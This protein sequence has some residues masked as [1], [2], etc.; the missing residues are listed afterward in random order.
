MKKKRRRLRYIR[1][2]TKAASGQFVKEERGTVMVL[3]I[4]FA[5]PL[6]MFLFGGFNVGSALITRMR[7]QNVADAASYTG[8]LW[9]ARFLNYC[10]YTRRHIIGNYATIALSTAYINNHEMYKNIHDADNLSPTRNNDSNNMFPPSVTNQIKI[11]KTALDLA[12]PAVDAVRTGSDQMNK[13]L[14]ASQYIMY[15]TVSDPN[16]VMGKVVEDFSGRQKTKFE[17][18]TTLSF[19]SLKNEGLVRYSKLG[20]QGIKEVKAYLDPYTTAD[21]PGPIAMLGRISWFFGGYGG[22][23]F[24]LPKK[25]EMN[26]FIRF[27]NY[28]STPVSVTN[29]QMKTK[30]TFV[31]LTNWYVWFLFWVDTPWGPVPVS[32][33]TP[34]FKE[35]HTETYKLKSK[36]NSTKVY[37]MKKD[38]EP[39]VLAVVKTRMNTAPFFRPIQMRPQDLYPHPPIRAF[40]RSKAYFKGWNENLKK[41]KYQKP[42]LNYPFWGAKL[43]DLQSGGPQMQQVLN[44]QLGPRAMTMR[45][46]Y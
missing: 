13:W 4:A 24:P 32:F 20:N 25:N 23:Y 21:A 33:A 34:F 7:A 36:F 31:P 40:S 1:R 29:T 3:T 22:T 9:H 19:G 44:S 28:K 16:T 12:R 37:E 11:S 26:G 15:S 8:A 41:N 6:C 45:P 46:N 5:L 2:M 17:L 42:D 39:E 30:S 43:A 18:D 10:A 27:V 38:K 35:G 14:S